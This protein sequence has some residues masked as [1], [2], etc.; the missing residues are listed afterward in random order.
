MALVDIK[1]LSYHKFT[2]F[3]DNYTFSRTYEQFANDLLTKD[4]DWITI[5]DGSECMIKACRM[6]T[7]QAIRGK[8]F[9]SSNLIGTEG[10]CTW[11]QIKYISQFHDI[12]NHSH[13]HVRLN[14]L[15]YNEIIKQMAA[16]SDLIKT[17]VG[18]RPRF[19]VPPWNKLSPMVM[20][21]CREL[22]MTLIKDRTDILKDTL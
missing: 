11:E 12:E 17:N 14:E 19:F 20:A 5:D 18:K 9:I 7:S 16:C 4:F 3:A 1:I 2:N 6:M 13:D 21:A 10:Y 8:I 15:E 22:G